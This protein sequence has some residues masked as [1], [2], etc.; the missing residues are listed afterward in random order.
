MEFSR[1]IEDLKQKLKLKEENGEL[2]SQFSRH[3]LAHQ[4][5][6][7]NPSQIANHQSNRNSISKEILVKKILINGIMIVFSRLV[8]NFG[9]LVI[10]L[11]NYTSQF[12]LHNLLYLVQL[13]FLYNMIS[14]GF[15]LAKQ[16]PLTLQTVPVPIQVPVQ[17]PIQAPAPAKDSPSPAK[18]TPKPNPTPA[19]SSTP[20]KETHTNDARD[21]RETTPI[22]SPRSS[23][24]TSNFSPKRVGT[25]HKLADT[26]ATSKLS[27]IPNL[28]NEQSSTPTYIPSP[29]Y[30]YRM[31]SP[32]R[33]RRK[34]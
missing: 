3:H 5:S 16:G 13:L 28:K 26:T 14:S 17:A 9:E 34:F 24:I 2:P 10:K 27:L 22:S 19:S 25:S 31:D 8:F 21:P 15:Q 12:D 11:L 23:V 6:D 30:Y 7:L 29:K 1:E 32:S 4:N 18:Q 33:T 20:S